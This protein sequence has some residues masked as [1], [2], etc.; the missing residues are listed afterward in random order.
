MIRVNL[1]LNLFFLALASIYPQKQFNIDSLI[2]IDAITS[3]NL[4]S[5]EKSSAKEKVSKKEK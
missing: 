5:A 2:K 3:G 1:A 4:K